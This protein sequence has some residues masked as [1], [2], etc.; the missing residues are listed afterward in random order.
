MA[1]KHNLVF[2]HHNHDF[3]FETLPGGELGEDLILGNPDGGSLMAELDTFWIHKAGKNPVEMI[4]KYGRRA[5]LIHIKDMTSDDA[6]TF[7]II[8][9][10]QMDFDAIFKAGDAQGVDWY[11][12]EQDLCPKGEI[13]SARASYNNLVARGWR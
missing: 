10:G 4:H 13:E 11:I 2:F 8:G 9:A 6:R 1:A 5:P 12:V 7:E 3:E